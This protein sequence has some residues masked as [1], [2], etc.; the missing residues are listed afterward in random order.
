[1][2]GVITCP[3]EWADLLYQIHEVACNYDV[4]NQL[5]N[6][7]SPSFWH[8]IFLLTLGRTIKFELYQDFDSDDLES[9][10]LCCFTS[11]FIGGPFYCGCKNAKFRVIL[12]DLGLISLTQVENVGFL[13]DNLS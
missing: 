7:L 5:K 1:M 13:I 10:I 4:V 8:E 2:R 11:P 12:F 3:I 6:I 9:I